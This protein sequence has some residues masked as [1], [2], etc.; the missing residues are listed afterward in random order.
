MVF[1]D[2]DRLKNINDSLGRALGDKF[3]ARIASVLEQV[4]G[5]K[6]TV[7]RLSGDEFVII[8]DEI[9]TPEQ[10]LRCAALKLLVRINGPFSNRR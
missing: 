5:D 9:Q 1:I 8:A 10:T 3:L 7:A 2:L 4:V 6:G